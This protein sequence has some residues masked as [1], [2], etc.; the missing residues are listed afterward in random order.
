MQ[1]VQVPSPTQSSERYT[2]VPAPLGKV[3]A[4]YRISGNRDRLPS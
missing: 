1:N 2:D 4:E 3:I